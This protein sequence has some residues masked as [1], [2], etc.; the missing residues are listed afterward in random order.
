[1]FLI[2]NEVLM[3]DVV[4]G[5]AIYLIAFLFSCFK[6]MCL[7]IIFINSKLNLSNILLT[8]LLNVPGYGLD[9]LKKILF[10]KMSKISLEYF[11][12]FR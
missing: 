4:Q 2:F 5:L 11:K 3:P 9:I 6:E 12:T 8:L 10:I 1:M 7:S